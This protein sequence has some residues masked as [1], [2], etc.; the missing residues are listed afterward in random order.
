VGEF[1]RVVD[2]F[3]LNFAKQLKTK[4]TVKGE[5]QRGLNIIHMKNAQNETKRLRRKRRIT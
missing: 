5:K 1:P 2:H 4:C 3:G